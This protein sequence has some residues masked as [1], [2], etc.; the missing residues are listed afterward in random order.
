[1]FWNRFGCVLGLT[2]IPEE[3]FR[4]MSFGRLVTLPMVFGCRRRAFH[5]IVGGDEI[6]YYLKQ[7]EGA[8]R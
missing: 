7:W 5:H 1:M 8:F 4:L 3:A 2:G 6:T